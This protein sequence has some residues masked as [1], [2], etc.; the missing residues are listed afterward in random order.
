[1]DL[2]EVSFGERF[3]LTGEKTC[4][5][6]TEEYCKGLLD[7]VGREVWMMQQRAIFLVKTKC[8]R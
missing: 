6:L 5:G 3:R 8:A 7:D 1:M 4:A 2:E